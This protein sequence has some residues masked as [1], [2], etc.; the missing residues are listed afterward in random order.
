MSMPIVLV[1]EDDPKLNKIIAFALEGNF[2]IE[3]HTDG[4]EA[5]QRLNQIVPDIIILDLNLPGL[6][7]REILEN[8]RADA[9]LA[10][11][12][13]ILTTADERQAETLTNE[14]D[15][16]LLKPVSPTQLRELALRMST[17]K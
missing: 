10:K 16:V 2:E 13:V 7:G 15:I 17:Q 3:T 6:S 5:M 11:T 9:R 1:I 14:V 4:V 12:R 8:V